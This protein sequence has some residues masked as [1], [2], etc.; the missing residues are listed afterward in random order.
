VPFP[1][2][3]KSDWD[4]S[5]TLGGTRPLLLFTE[6]H[7]YPYVHDCGDEFVDLGERGVLDVQP[8]RGNPGCEK[9]QKLDKER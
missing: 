6:N 5:V 4:I 9:I 7:N 2:Y 3:H 8:V 1:S